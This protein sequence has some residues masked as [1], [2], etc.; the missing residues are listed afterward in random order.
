MRRIRSLS[1]PSQREQRPSP[2]L[3][4]APAG[5]VATRG[6]VAVAVLEEELVLVV[7][8]RLNNL[9]RQAKKCRARHHGTTNSVKTAMAVTF[10]SSISLEDVKMEWTGCAGKVPACACIYAQP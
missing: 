5:G 8:G 3:T 7:E 6:A 9:L 1:L 4:M 10:V 2:F